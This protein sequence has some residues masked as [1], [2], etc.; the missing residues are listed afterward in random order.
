M[1]TTMNG[2]SEVPLDPNSEKAIFQLAF[3]NT[4]GEKGIFDI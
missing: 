2:V 4:V 1:P 3:P